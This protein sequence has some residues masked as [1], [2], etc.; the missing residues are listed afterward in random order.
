MKL[1]ILVTNI[2][3]QGGVARVISNLANEFAEK[4]DI[5]VEIISVFKQNSKLE[6]SFNE[7]ISLKYLDLDMDLPIN[8][9]KKQIVFSKEVNKVIN[10]GNYN[11]VLSTNAFLNMYAVLFKNK[12]SKTKIIGSEHGAYTHLGSG[13]R[14]ITKILYKRLDSFVL[15]TEKEKDK[16]KEYTKDIQVIPNMM[17]FE[18][19]EISDLEHKNIISVGR[20]DENK[21]ISNL[22]DVFKLVSEKADEWTL[23]IC[24]SGEK[25]DVELIKEKIKEYNLNKK[26]IL[27]DFTNNIKKEFLNSAIFVMTSKSE[28]LPMVMIEASSLGLPCISYD[29]LTGP[30]DIIQNNK[31]GYLI[32]PFDTE[33]MAEGIL[34]LIYNK[35]KMIEFSKHA[36]KASH[37]FKKDLIVEKWIKLF[38]SL[39]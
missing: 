14:A 32:E 35:E 24:G 15:L 13:W 19:D 5:N 23:T 30:S 17:T 9:I 1:A 39:N 18:S 12:K 25:E 7:R 3:S 11:I 29:I 33:K 21:N 2:N 28:G 37:R 26:I 22:V 8:K 6:Y 4:K 20:I 38:D 16:Y 34:D 36:K 27:K 10:E 31:S